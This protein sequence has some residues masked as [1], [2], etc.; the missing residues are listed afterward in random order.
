MSKNI[1]QTFIIVQLFIIICG[2]VSI[3][4]Q[5]DWKAWKY[6]L[7][8]KLTH[9]SSQTQGLVPLPKGAVYSERNLYYFYHNTDSSGRIDSLVQLRKAVQSGPGIQIGGYRLPPGE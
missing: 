1:I 6:R 9:R 8:L 2:A 5:N 3:N 4:A 7:P